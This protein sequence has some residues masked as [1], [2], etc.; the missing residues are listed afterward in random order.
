MWWYGDIFV[1]V[2]GDPWVK[3]PHVT[4]AQIVVSRQINKAFTGN[5]DAPMITFPLFPGKEM[6]YLRC[7]IARITSTTH[8]SPIGYFQTLEEE[9]EDEE[10]GSKEFD[11]L[12]ICI[13]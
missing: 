12:K 3:L 13:I 1:L 9:E 10:Q 8:I 2:A 7:Q 4:P 11:L 6:N 5:L